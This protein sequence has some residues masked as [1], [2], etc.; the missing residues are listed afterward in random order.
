MLHAVRFLSEAEVTEEAR[1]SPILGI[2]DRCDPVLAERT[3]QILQ[4][5]AHCLG[6]QSAPLVPGFQ[7]DAQLDLPWLILA[8][9]QPAI[10][11]ESP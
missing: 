1:G 5:A 2:G 10:T 11:N 3:E 7:R 8:E 6:C 4:Y 9:M